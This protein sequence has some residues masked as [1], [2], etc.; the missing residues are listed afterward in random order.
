MKRLLMIF[1]MAGMISGV[2]AM[3]LGVT[4]S[5]TDATHLDSISQSFQGEGGKV[6]RRRMSH[7]AYPV[8]V[9]MVGNAVKVD[10]P[11]AQ[12]LPIYTHAGAFYLILRLNKGTN[13]VSG[14]PEGK[15]FINSRLVTI[16]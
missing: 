8:R 5:N 10:S 16:K 11:E 2:A 3:P 14:L 6:I 15:Y 4:K 12:L 7:S 9:Q 13:W 1:L